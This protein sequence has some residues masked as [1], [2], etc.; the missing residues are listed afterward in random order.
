MAKRD[1]T[2]KRI[3]MSV[4]KFYKHDEQDE[5][6]AYGFDM[7]TNEHIRVRMSSSEEFTNII[8]KL[9]KN[10]SDAVSIEDVHTKFDTGRNQRTSLDTHNRGL[11]RGRI[12][13]FD[14]CD[15]VQN[16]KLG[17]Y[18]SYVAQWCNVMSN[19][20]NSQLIKSVASINVHQQRSGDFYVKAQIIEDA[21]HL[22]VPNVKLNSPALHNAIIK[23]NLQ[24]LIKSLSNS[25]ED[26][27]ERIPFSKLV[28]RYE[29]GSVLTTIPLIPTFDTANRESVKQFA[30]P[31]PMLNTGGVS[32][33]QKEYRIAKAPIDS[34]KD[35]LNG[36]DFHTSTYNP[37]FVPST[38]VE[39]EQHQKQAQNVYVMDQA[40]IAL[41]A[42][43]GD[44]KVKIF[45][46]EDVDANKNRNLK[47]LY[48]G[49][50]S[51]K[52]LPEIYHGQQ[53]Q[54]G[55]LYKD[56]FLKKFFNNKTPHAGFRKVDPEIDLRTGLGVRGLNA[57][58]L[59]NNYL[60]S[61]GEPKPHDLNPQFLSLVDR[62]TMNKLTHAK[63][64]FAEAFI[65]I[66]PHQRNSN[67][68][69]VSF[70][71]PVELTQTRMNSLEF[72]DIT[73]EYIQEHKAS[74]DSPLSHNFKHDLLPDPEQLMRTLRQENLEPTKE[75]KKTK[76]NTSSYDGLTL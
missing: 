4:D 61:N 66:Q 65:V 18:K 48:A 50:V 64:K 52:L 44:R 36:D 35:I 69:F 70:I 28:V 33:S 39:K 49:L 75:K 12:I 7:A 54:L 56:T 6:Y 63:Q 11:N 41:F 72:S 46:N 76:E 14:K 51:Q 25:T 10:H 19:S 9:N 71:E 42:L 32:K 62:Q 59:V 43:L 20:P 34:I 74:I 47:K 53:L 27:P 15:E 26:Q 68:C 16:E 60:D 29:N 3:I 67:N 5:L 73:V 37:N 38:E 2:I 1:N 45:F 21:A 13:C 55:A 24:T 30:T 31:D 58:P 57:P 8:N 22:Q 40:R 17:E 23:N